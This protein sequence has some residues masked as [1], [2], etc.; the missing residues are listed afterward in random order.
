[1]Q[2]W[3]DDVER[4]WHKLMK[5]EQIAN[6]QVR[7]GRI[8]IRQVVVTRTAMHGVRVF[9]NRCPHAGAPLSGGRLQGDLLICPR[10]HWEY[11]VGDGSCAEHP[12]YALQPY[13]VRIEDGWI[14]AQ[15][16]EE[17]RW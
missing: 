3:D 9:N 7:L 17:E 16:R 1:M 15:E 14:L 13:Q 5:D 6:G 11:S 8:G 4:P 2:F 12:L 10:H